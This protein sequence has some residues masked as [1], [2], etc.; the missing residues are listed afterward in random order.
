[1]HDIN[2]TPAEQATTKERE[3]TKAIG[4]QRRE[5]SS[6]RAG[7]FL[8]KSQRKQQIINYLLCKSKGNPKPKIKK[9]LVCV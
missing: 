8:G 7:K 6:P 5:S 9:W 4:V 3:K 2:V 1:M